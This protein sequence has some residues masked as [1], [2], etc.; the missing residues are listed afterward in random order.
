MKNPFHRKT[1]LERIAS[2]VGKMMSPLATQAPRVMKSGL[3]AAG[4]F[5]GL[6]LASAAVSRARQRQDAE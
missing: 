4:T 3:T 2:P 1:T 5:I 6:S